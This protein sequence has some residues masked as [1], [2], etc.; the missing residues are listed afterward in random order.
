MDARPDGAISRDAAVEAW[1][2]YLEATRSAGSRYAEL[3]P[4]AWARLSGKLQEAGL[5]LP[6]EAAA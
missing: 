4:W 2:E 5:V 6:D 1:L 3:E